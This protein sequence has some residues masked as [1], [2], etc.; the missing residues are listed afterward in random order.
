M[1]FDWVRFPDSIFPIKNNEF[2]TLMCLESSENGAICS[3]T[4]TL[5]K[6]ELR[7]KWLLIYW[8][9]WEQSK[10]VYTY[11]RNHWTDTENITIEKCYIWIEIWNTYFNA[12]GYSA[13]FSVIWIYWW[14]LI[15]DALSYV[16]SFIWNEQFSEFFHYKNI[17]PTVHKLFHK[18]L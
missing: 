3:I 11:G 7:C 13:R 4:Q 1:T 16:S 6:W 9:F 14:E 15:T 17:R 12:V 2:I 18:T 5:R 8:V 10:H